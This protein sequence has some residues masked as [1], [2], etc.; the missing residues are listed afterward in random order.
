[1]GD[2]FVLKNYSFDLPFVPTILAIALLSLGAMWVLVTLDD[3]NQIPSPTPRSVTTS[4]GT[5]TIHVVEF[6][7]ASD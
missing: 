2:A 5:A 3:A 6:T 4:S 1:M 7:T